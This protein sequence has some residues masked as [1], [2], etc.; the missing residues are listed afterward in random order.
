MAHVGADGSWLRVNQQVCD[1]LGY[2]SDELMA[3]T[4][5]DLTHPADL[6]ID[7]DLAGQVLNGE[8]DRYKLQKRYF[9][10]DGHIVWANLTVA[11]VRDD[12]G[13]F[14]HFISVLEDISEMRR[15]HITLAETEE[16]FR[17]LQETSP[18]GFMTL[19]SV[20][21]EIGRIVDFRWT[22]AN[23]AAEK[24]VGRPASYLLGRRMLEEMPGNLEEGLF[25]AY[26]GVVETGRTW[27]KEFDYNHDGI[28]ARFRTTAARAGDGFA[29][30][31]AD[32]TDLHRSEERLRRVL[33]S[34]VAYIAVLSKDGTLLQVNEP[35]LDAANLSRKD[36]LGKPFWDTYWLNHSEQSRTQIRD[37][38]ARAARGERIRFDAEVR[39]REGASRVVD[40]KLAPLYNETG[41]V[42]EIIASGVDITDR[43]RGEEHREMLLRELSHRVK[44]TLATVQAMA[45]HTMRNSSDFARFQSAYKGRLSAIARCHDLLVA[46][47]HVRVEISDLISTQVR[48][49]ARGDA[50]TVV[51]L[52]GEPLVLSGEAAHAFALVLH[53]LATNAAKYGALSNQT[54]QVKIAWDKVSDE[55]GNW[56]EITWTEVGGPPVTEP[57]R[58]GFG[59][60]LIKQSLSHTLGGSS[61][62]SYTE[63]GLAAN[64]RLPVKAAQ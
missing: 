24:I 43:K 17:A 15:M 25:D 63:S 14:A 23:A 12:S 11:A 45:N 35:S 20:R 41:Q 33:N 44:N 52:D 58:L 59:S 54:G 46:T 13:Q 62:V 28:K 56:I 36:V 26:V 5:Q 50:K 34:V 60:T 7:V 38:V 57:T 32:V 47:E 49:Y 8:I 31:F 2:K 42:H 51:V 18:D 3:L 64:F 21:N 22:Y 19:E 6:N 48:P 40:M 39:I 4:F 16:R 61:S 30:S 1:M 29:V 53:E 10:K 55:T 27:H 37:A 9:H